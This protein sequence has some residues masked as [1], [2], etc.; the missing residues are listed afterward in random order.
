[1]GPHKRPVR[2]QIGTRILYLHRPLLRDV[3][4]NRMVAQ[5]LCLG[6]MAERP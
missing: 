3:P 2:M 4:K 1:M 5:R 6:Q